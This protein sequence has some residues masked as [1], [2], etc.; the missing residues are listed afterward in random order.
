[1]LYLFVIIPGV[2][3]LP[4]IWTTLIFRPDSS[5]ACST[6]SCYATIGRRKML[7]LVEAGKQVNAPRTVARQP[8]ITTIEKLFEAVFSVGSAPRLYSEDPR[9]AEWV[10]LRDIHWIVATWAREAEESL[11][12]RSRCYG[13]VFGDTT[14]CENT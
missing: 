8:P 11:L 5:V 12:F 2:L 13:T 7:R 3:Y 9:P 4:P 10:Q 6:Y 1:M 14:G